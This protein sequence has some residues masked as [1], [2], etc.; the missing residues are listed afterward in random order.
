M[1]QSDGDALQRDVK[2]LQRELEEERARAS[3]ARGRLKEVMERATALSTRTSADVSV[4]VDRLQLEVNKLNGQFESMGR[5][6]ETLENKLEQHEAKL[7][8]AANGPS[9]GGGRPTAATPAD[10]NELFNTGNQRIA[11]GQHE[12]G[13]RLLRHFIARYPSDPRA[14]R[15]QLMLGNSYYAQQ[16]LAPAIQEYRKVIERHAGT[17]VMP[18]TLYKIGMSF[19]QLKYCGDAKNFFLELT[20]RHGKSGYAKKARAVLKR[21]RRYRRNSRICSS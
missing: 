3:V 18:E 2:R 13:R 19:Y 20:K 7:S 8:S 11:A 15:A 1:S 16:K 21:I 5:K 9:S 17:S 10:P 14:A 6:I 4:Q 12:A